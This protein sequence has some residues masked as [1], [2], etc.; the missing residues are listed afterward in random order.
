MPLFVARLGQLKVVE[1]SEEIRLDLVKT[2]SQI[3]L[4]TGDNFAPFVEEVSLVLT[5]IMTDSFPDIRKVELLTHIS[6]L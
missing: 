5:R 2:L 6:L 1:S 3:V 4:K